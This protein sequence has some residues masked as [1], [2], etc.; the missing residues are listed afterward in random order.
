MHAAMGLVSTFLNIYS[1]Q[2]GQWSVTAVITTCIIGTWLIV[3]F[4]LY[5]LYGH[6]LLP[7]LKEK[8][9]IPVS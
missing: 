3:S 6:I 8:R 1:M 2:D 5:I 9:W 7:K 4:A